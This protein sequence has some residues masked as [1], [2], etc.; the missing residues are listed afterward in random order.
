MDVNVLNL[1]E[2]IDKTV[3]KLLEIKINNRNNNH[4]KNIK[5]EINKY[6]LND[7]YDTDFEVNYNIGG[8]T[9]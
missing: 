6:W 5:I 9:D 2:T 8:G 4:I 7:Y 3:E 1:E